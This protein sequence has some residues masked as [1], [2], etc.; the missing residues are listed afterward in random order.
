M[1]KKFDLN[2]TEYTPYLPLQ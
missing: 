2:V 1:Y